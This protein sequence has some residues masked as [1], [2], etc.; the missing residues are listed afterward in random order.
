MASKEPVQYYGLKEMA[1]LAK[2]EG[3]QYTTRQL[4]VYKGR[5]LLPEPTVMI[6][7]KAGWTKDQIDEW[8]EQA[9]MKKGRH[10]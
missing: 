7:D 6:G 4:S 1:D 3:I 8:L 2:E 5:G 10:K 9:K